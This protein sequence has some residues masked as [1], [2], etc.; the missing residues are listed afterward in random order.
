MSSAP[1]AFYLI[2]RASDGRAVGGI[3]FKEKPDDGRVEIGVGLV[4]S[5]RGNGYAAEAV[6]AVLAV[7][8]RHG[9]E[10]VVAD[11]H[12]SNIASQRTLEAAR[13][14]RR[15]NDADPS[16]HLYEATLGTD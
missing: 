7:A 2:T 15:R 10:Q 13:F 12:R 3:G 4:P 14:T 5:A 11:T 6:A 8:A 9:L 1:S 16:L